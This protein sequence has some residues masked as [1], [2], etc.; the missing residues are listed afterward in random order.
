MKQDKSFKLANEA[1]LYFII[2]SEH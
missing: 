2:P 1:R